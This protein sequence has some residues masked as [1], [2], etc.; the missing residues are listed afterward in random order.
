MEAD[1]LSKVLNI[2]AVDLL[3]SGDNA[4]VIAMAVASLPKE[5]A[6]KAAIWGAVG[7][8]GL[9]IVFAALA[10]LLLGIPLLEAIGGLLLFW[11]AWKLLVGE[12]DDDENPAGQVTHF[13]HAVRTIILADVVM[14][15]DNILAVGGASHG[16]LKLLLFGL[17]L[18]IPIVL[19]GSSLLTKVLHRFPAI[20]Y[21]GAAI[22]VNLAAQ[23]FLNDKFVRQYGAF[24]FDHVPAWFADYGM[25]VIAIVVV[26][27]LGYLRARKAHAGAPVEKTGDAS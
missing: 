2:V 15:L 10:A 5:L 11:I 6:R 7:A 23:M 18:S 17:A 22:L 4:V 12:G 1:F 24:F 21:V 27:G 20:A 19:F 3:L 8:V 9:R 16:D 14:S 25:R 26:C 13:F